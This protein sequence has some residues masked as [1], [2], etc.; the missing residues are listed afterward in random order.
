MCPF[1][2]N[3]VDAGQTVLLSVSVGCFGS[4][5]FFRLSSLRPKKWQAIYKAIYSSQ[6]NA[7]K[8]TV[9]T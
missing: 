1:L 9:K 5:D 3:P 8:F 6:K 4:L 7:I 2:S